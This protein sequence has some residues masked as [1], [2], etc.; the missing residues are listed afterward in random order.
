MLRSV[1]AVLTGLV[2]TVLLVL[3][4]TLLLTASLE[5]P[6]DGTPG[7][8]FLTLNLLTGALAGVAGGATAMKL[9]PHTPHGHVV[10]LAGVLVLLSL[11]TMFAAPAPGQPQWYGIVISILGP[12][13]VL[14]GGFLG[15][16]LRKDVPS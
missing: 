3:L 13:S 11:P 1:V 6:A 5:L 8:T 7:S 2:V 15:M 14:L 9:A 4:S 10:A 12:V 16:R